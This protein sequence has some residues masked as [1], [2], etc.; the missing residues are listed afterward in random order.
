MPIN[1]LLMTHRFT[2]ER[3]AINEGDGHQLTPQ[4]HCGGGAE[5]MTGAQNPEHN[6]PTN[7]LTHDERAGTRAR[8]W[9]DVISILAC[10]DCVRAHR[11]KGQAPINTLFAA[12]LTVCTS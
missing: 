2:F 6:Q 1:T 11:D 5:V 4:P 7:Q 3:P 12:A 10:T 8:G 9:A